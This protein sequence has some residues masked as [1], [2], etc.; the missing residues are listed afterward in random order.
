LSYSVFAVL[1]ASNVEPDYSAARPVV[2]VHVPS[3]CE[4]GATVVGVWYNKKPYYCQWFRHNRYAALRKLLE[5]NRCKS[6]HVSDRGRAYELFT[7]TN[8]GEVSRAS[9][10]EWARNPSISDIS[11]SAQSAICIDTLESLSQRLVVTASAKDALVAQSSPRNHRVAVANDI[12]DS[13][14][15]DVSSSATISTM[16]DVSSSGSHGTFIRQVKV[17]DRVA[18]SS[19]FESLTVCLLLFFSL[20]TH[21]G[22]ASMMHNFFVLR[23]LDERKHNHLSTE[24]KHV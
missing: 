8:S 6:K 16:Q 20:I 13:T 24:F 4:C 3:F 15:Q 18:E 17:G 11:S 23:Y 9:S 14:V 22:P 19:P 5:Q 7:T 2:D 1:F 12:D 10:S 21:C